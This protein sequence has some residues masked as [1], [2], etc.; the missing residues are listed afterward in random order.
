MKKWINLFIAALFITSFVFA[1]GVLNSMV[2][3]K[4]ETTSPEQCISTV[5]GANLCDAIQFNKTAAKVSFFIAVVA[6]IYRLYFI[7][8][9]ETD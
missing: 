2:S 5:T 1:F 4:Y 8:N 9:K 3:L 6:I 7:K